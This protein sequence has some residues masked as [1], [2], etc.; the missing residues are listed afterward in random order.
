[1]AKAVMR[2]ERPATPGNLGRRETSSSSIRRRVTGSSTA[3]SVDGHDVAGLAEVVEIYGLLA[4]S[5]ELELAV[6][7]GESRVILSYRIE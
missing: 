2:Q 4:G 5:E 1:M 6:L 7:R 3:S